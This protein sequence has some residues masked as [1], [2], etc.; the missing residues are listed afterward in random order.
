M[1]IG[2]MRLVETRS[3]DVEADSLA[4]LRAAVAAQLDRGGK[5][6]ATLDRWLKR[7]AK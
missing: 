2:R 3:I 1:L 4:A 7:I 6:I 5:R